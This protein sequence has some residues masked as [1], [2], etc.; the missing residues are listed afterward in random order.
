M[1]RTSPPPLKLDYESNPV[2][3]NPSRRHHHTQWSKHISED[4]E[5]LI[6]CDSVSRR[7][8]NRSTSFWG[9][10]IDGKRE[11]MTLNDPSYHNGQI[12]KW[13]RFV[14]NTKPE[15]WHGYPL[16]PDPGRPNPPQNVLLHWARYRPLSKAKVAK[17]LR[18]RR[19]SF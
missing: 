11:L 1:K 12:A 18:G 6:F 14:S 4:E 3:R 7:W 10:K 5:F 13:C 17:L 8:G 9:I 15:I 2:H 19:C 16:W